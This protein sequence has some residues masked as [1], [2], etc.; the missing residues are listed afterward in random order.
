MRLHWS[1]SGHLLEIE[2]RC[3]LLGVSIYFLDFAKT[4]T[5]S[6][7]C[8]QQI[9]KCF[10]SHLMSCFLNIV[11]VLPR[12]CFSSRYWISN[13]VFAIKFEASPPLSDWALLL[14]LIG[15]LFIYHLLDKDFTFHLSLY[16]FINLYFKNHFPLIHEFS[17]LCW[18]VSLEMIDFYLFLFINHVY[19]DSINFLSSNTPTSW[20]I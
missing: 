18:L 3:S 19:F 7:K 6:V 1:F 12:W 11:A 15:E 17:F 9:F 8:Y 20:K 4:W 5:V 16:Y 14:G 10:D 13:F 2:R